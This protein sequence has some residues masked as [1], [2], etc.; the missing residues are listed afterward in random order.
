MDTQPQPQADRHVRDLLYRITDD[1]KTLARDEVEL[2]RDELKAAARAAALDVGAAL[3]GAIVALVGL[4]MLCVV[5]V[6]ALAP[7][8]P[9]LWARLL[10]MA[11]VYLVLGT[12]VAAGFASRLKT[13]VPSFAPAKYEARRTI[14]GAIETITKTEGRTHA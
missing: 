9:A 10:V 5:V 13:D 1:V 8:I 3:L 14:K 6:V 11:S 4:G 12:A 2:V 7:V